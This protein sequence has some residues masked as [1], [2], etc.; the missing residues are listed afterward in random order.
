MQADIFYKT[1]V[2]TQ[3]VSL[4]PT[5]IEVDHISKQYKVGRQRIAALSD[6]TLQI[7]EGELVAIVGASGSG[8]STLLQLIGG[9]DKPSS[10]TVTVNGIRLDKMRD[11]KLSAFRNQ[12][13]GFVFQFFYLQP[14]LNVERNIEVAAMPNHMKQT[15]RKARIT[16]LAEQVGLNDRLKHLP[17]E[18]SG[19]QIQRAAIARALINEP[20]IILA[21]EPTGNLD[22]ENSREVIALL[23]QIRAASGTTIV[24][25]T[26]NPEIA[27]EADRIITVKDG[28]VI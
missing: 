7:K 2:S 12:T 16:A 13:I 25:A 27:A 9:L 23:R 11:S 6:V 24:I 22:S 1:Q 26:H 21:D 10:G 20:S 5:I 15:E 19:G 28:A 17:R 8:K 18:L 3:P 14:F 4:T